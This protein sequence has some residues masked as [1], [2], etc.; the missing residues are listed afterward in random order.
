[1]GRTSRR[2]R[3]V[4]CGFALVFRKVDM[5]VNIARRLSRMAVRVQAYQ[6]INVVL[7][8]KRRGVLLNTAAIALGGG[9][10]ENGCD[11][12]VAL[13]A[14]QPLIDV[15]QMKKGGIP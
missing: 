4:G 5:N 6:R 7:R 13:V 1:M 14:F 10:F 12:A 11:M 15:R 8:F 9:F 3:S 2:R